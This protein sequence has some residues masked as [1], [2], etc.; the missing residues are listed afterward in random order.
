MATG[1][2]ISSD[3]ELAAAQRLAR[4]HWADQWIKADKAGDAAAKRYA[5]AQ[6]QVQGG[7]QRSHAY[8]IIDKVKKDAK[9][10]L[11]RKRRS[12]AGDPRFDAD[13]VASWIDFA[14]DPRK[15]PWPLKARIEAFEKAYRG[16]RKTWPHAN[17][18]RRWYAE[19]DPAYSMTAREFETSRR[20]F[21][22]MGAAYPN[23]VGQADQHQAD[24]EVV[25]YEVD[26]RTGEIIGERTFRP[27]LFTFADCYSGQVM[28]GIYYE[29]SHTAYSTAIVAQTLLAA[30]YPHP[31][32]GM[33]ACGVPEILYWDNGKPHTSVW[34]E[35]VAEALGIDLQYSKPRVPTSHGFIEGYH[36]TII[37]G[38]E[39][40][41]PG[42]T[43]KNPIDKPLERRLVADGQ[44]A[45]PTLKTLAQINADWQAYLPEY[46]EAEYRAGDPVDGG[47][48]RRVR[49]ERDVT[50]ERRAVPNRSQLALEWMQRTPKN[51][52]VSV[53][54]GE[55]QFR[56]VRYT[57][58]GLGDLDGL[59]VELRW[60]DGVFE[61]LWCYYD[62]QFYCELTP[63]QRTIYD[64]IDG[65]DDLK[66]RNRELAQSRKALAQSKRANRASAA[67][68]LVDDETAARTEQALTE[69]EEALR[70]EKGLLVVQALRE[71]DAPADDLPDNV[72]ALA[73]R[74]L[75][76]DLKTAP[77]PDLPDADPYLVALDGGRDDAEP[78]AAL[79]YL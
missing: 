65:W 2:P 62:G 10:A 3:E 53:H 66:E 74:L 22:S 18:F 15:Q 78:V 11:E 19:V 64:P 8:R 58:P 55:I 69:A 35:R 27:L 30:M 7:L 63:K 40:L 39:R 48:C 31:E 42:Y 13:L 54:G 79:D 14:T 71:A 6:L 24:F 20:R 34:I 36:N 57:G 72:V 38:F 44:I 26:K 5:F 25:A 45:A 33:P 46:H 41:Q 75:E 70:G 50:P 21:L 32:M 68:G 4:V 12:D 1:A 73:P 52:P 43:G 23:Q 37:N 56:T 67:A 47:L 9:T 61:R 17:S 28:A 51:R 60:V 76:F 49:W 16:E 29:G 77:A 59:K